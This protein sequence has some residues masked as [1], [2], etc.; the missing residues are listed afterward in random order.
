MFT[1]ITEQD[2]KR[3]ERYERKHLIYLAS[4]LSEDSGISSHR[5]CVL[6]AR[7]GISRPCLCSSEWRQSAVMECAVPVSEVVPKQ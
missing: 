1:F 7:Q 5:S 3:G 6:Q 4:I 2:K